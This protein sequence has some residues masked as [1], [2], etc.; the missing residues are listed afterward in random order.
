MQLQLPV[1]LEQS[2]NDEIVSNKSL[3]YAENK[4]NIRVI[5]INNSGHYYY[6]QEAKEQIINTLNDFIIEVTAK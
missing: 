5:K 3:T 6:P 2:I 4:Q 1:V